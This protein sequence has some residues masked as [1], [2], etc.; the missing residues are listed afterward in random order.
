MNFFDS[1]PML[2]GPA[3][4]AGMGLVFLSRLTEGA[5]EKEMGFF[6]L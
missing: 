4:L 6:S 5:L 2:H 3:L 1:G